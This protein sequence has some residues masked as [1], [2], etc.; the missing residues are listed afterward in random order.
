MSDTTEIFV[1]RSEQK[2]DLHIRMKKKESGGLDVRMKS[3]VQAMFGKGLRRTIEE[4]A[5][6]LGL[7]S[8]EIE[9]DDRGALE[10]V[11]QARLEA[12]AR[13]LHEVKEPGLLPKRKAPGPRP[14]KDRLRRTRLYL[15][16]NNPDLM[17]NAGLFGADCV[18]LDL[19]DSVAPAEKD[20]ARVLVRNTLLS[21]DFESAER[22][23]R[24]NPLSTEFG[25]RDLEMIVPAGPETILVP[26]CDEAADIERIDEI[27][28]AI[29]K[30]HKIEE[31]TLIMPLL[32]T[33]KGALNAY[34]IASASDRVVALCFGAEDFTADVGVERTK[35]GTESFVARSLIV[36]GAKAARVQAIDTV[37]SDVSDEE[38]LV[39]STK[40][41][42]ALGFEGKGVIHPR[43][44]G[45]IHRVFSPTPDRIA[46]AKQVVSAIEDAR[47][48]G[49]GVAT[50][51]SKMIDAPIEIRAR[52]ILR[53]AEALGLLGEEE[54]SKKE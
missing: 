25:L 17:L 28:T 20:A 18:I 4:S 44:I 37:F 36:L 23:V 27:M 7:A 13:R 45:P 15:P 38:G 53:L 46:Y 8:I 51:K 54:E 22:I 26:K 1:G 3:S 47:A 32:E 10:Y 24:I 9:V 16:G 34:R 6:A 19:E 5:K 21:V 43:Q 48:R 50:I 39:A 11:I 52:K 30:K 29:E 12:G 33:A 49:S 14:V 35:E 41:A 2:S 40:E 31:K 42:M